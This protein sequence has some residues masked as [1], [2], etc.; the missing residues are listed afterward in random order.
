MA[1]AFAQGPLTQRSAG[2]GMFAPMIAAVFSSVAVPA[3]AI[4][5]GIGVTAGFTFLQ[6]TSRL[7]KVSRRPSPVASGGPWRHALVFAVLAGPAVLVTRSLELGHGYW[8]VL[9]WRRYFSPLLS[10]AEWPRATG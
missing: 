5:I 4:A 3:S 8:L 2:V 9:T 1:L 7:L 6:A 10:H